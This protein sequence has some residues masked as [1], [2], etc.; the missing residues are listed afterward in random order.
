[1][2]DFSVNSDYVHDGTTIDY[3]KIDGK[4]IQIEGENKSIRW[5]GTNMAI[6]LDSPLPP[7]QD[8]L[9]ETGWEVKLPG[10]SR[11]ERMGAYGDSAAFVAYW[12][13][14]IA[15]YDDI[16][17]W[18]YYSHTGAQEFYHEF[19]DFDVEITVPGN[20]LVWATG[21]LQNADDVLTEKYLK[22]YQEAFKSDDII[23]ILTAEDYIDGR[24]TEPND[25]NTWHFKASNI[26]DF[27]FAVSDRYLWDGTSL[28]VDENDKRRVMVDAVYKK[29][30]KELYDLAEIA[31]ET[32]KYLSFELPGVPFPY[33]QMTVFNGNL[34]G[35]M[36]FPMI[37]NDATTTSRART[38]GLTAHEIAH[39]YFPFYMGTN[40]KKY[41]WM[42]E[43]WAVMLPFE[44]QKRMV[45]NYDPIPRQMRYFGLISGQEMDLPLMTPSVLLQGR[46]LYFAS[47]TRPGVAYEMLKNLMGKE[48]FQEAL[49][50][51]IDRWNGKHPMPYDFFFTFNEYYGESLN[52]FW[53][54]WFFERGYPD[55]GIASVS[56]DKNET[57]VVIE[58]LGN[59]PVP[60]K[61]RIIYS[62]NSDQVINKS[63]DV[64]KTGNIEYSIKFEHE[65]EIKSIELGDK[66]IPDKHRENNHYTMVD[67]NDN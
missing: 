44:F 57:E 42:D 60:I 3:L 64:W 58:K 40:E 31:K 26:P 39:T 48:K 59:N 15:V 1:M 43:G 61:L 52:W 62:D 10:E 49:E 16:E 24:I 51:F 27:A 55:L 29:G 32:V 13:P 4:N 34:G 45:D 11:R 37:A 25:K 66:Y 38:V 12:Y 17:G 2:R 9:V 67:F 7:G 14:E 22:R 53:K 63:V 50:V 20:F 54:S 21:L 46:S 36:E 28:I 56:K 65:L 23:H 19:G 8:F 35:G 47:Y 30:S 33:P 6:T 5:F 41:A 18:D